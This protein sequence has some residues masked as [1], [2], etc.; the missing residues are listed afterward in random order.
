M[1]SLIHPNTKIGHI[2]IRVNNLERSEVFYTEVLGFKVLT[3]SD[4]TV[5]L[6]VNG[7]EPLV[8]LEQLAE[9]Y[10]QARRAFAGLYHFAILVPD[11]ASLGL[12]LRNMSQS[13]I[14]IGQGDHLV[15]EALYISDPDNNGIEIYRD[16]PRDEWEWDASGHVVMTTDPVDVEGLVNA[17]ADL[18]WNGL[19]AD[20]IMG[21]LHFHVSDLKKAEEFY[22]HILGFEITCVYGGQALFAGAGGYHH[23][24]GMNTW[25][26]VG[27]LN[28]PKVAPGIS[29]YTLV[30]PNEQSRAEVLD[31]V[32]SAG[33][34]LEQQGEAWVLKDVSDV[35]V[36]LVVESK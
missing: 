3:R 33:L 14:Q 28:A 13:G 8:I 5:E 12:V 6:T 27:A 18:P 24:I 34:A 25:A 22:A 1:T 15:S 9:E 11:R 10:V 32:R 2:Q 4:H 20:T 36:K 21:H 19:P 31:R 17:S 29:Y 26:G 30:L 35:E 7:T 23:H 16:R